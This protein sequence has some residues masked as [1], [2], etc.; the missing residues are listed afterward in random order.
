M[1]K[2]SKSDIK[3]YIASLPNGP[4]KLRCPH[5]EK[6]TGIPTDHPV[7]IPVQYFIKDLNIRKV[8]EMTR[9]KY[10]W[11]TS[12]SRNRQ[13]CFKTDPNNSGNDCNNWKMDCILLKNSGLQRKK[14]KGNRLHAQQQKMFVNDTC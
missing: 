6:L 7:K 8:T 4:G 13:G 1:S 11:N 2:L 9:G 12:R 5:V 3:N 14:N 10:K